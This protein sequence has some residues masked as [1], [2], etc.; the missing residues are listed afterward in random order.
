MLPTRLP[1]PFASSFPLYQAPG[2]FWHTH[3]G[4]NTAT[5]GFRKP[6]PSNNVLVESLVKSHRAPSY[7]SEMFGCLA[8]PQTSST[9]CMAHVPVLVPID[10]FSPSACCAVWMIAGVFPEAPFPL[11][12][13]P[14][15]QVSSGP[16]PGEHLPSDRTRRAGVGRPG[17]YLSCGYSYMETGDRICCVGLLGVPWINNRPPRAVRPSVCR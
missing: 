4:P 13:S 2:C 9:Y 14:E 10:R 15:R 3:Q 16:R 11:S 6:C 5:G 8:S 12:R 1:S 17:G 7:S